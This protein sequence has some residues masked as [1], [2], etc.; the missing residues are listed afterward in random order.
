[1]KCP[2]CKYLGTKVLDSR[3]AD[4]GNTTRRRRECEQCQYRFTTFERIEA[5]PIVVIKKDGSQEEFNKEKI[6]K[7]LIRACE[8]RPVTIPRLQE[9]TG[10]VEA[11][12]RD[13][14]MLEVKSEYIG[15]LVLLHLAKIDDVAYVRFASVYRRFND[16]N[17][18]FEELKE[19][20]NKEK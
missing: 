18:F 14:G 5:V 8:K 12:L 10:E 2:S 20:L 6:L 13:K 9:M 17:V 7:G 4:E 3:T 15:E 1:M 19:L 11:D 16:L